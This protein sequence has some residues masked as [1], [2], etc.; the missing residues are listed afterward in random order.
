MAQWLRPSS[1]YVTNIAV[2]AK[3][4]NSV[5]LSTD[6]LQ[7]RIGM[8]KAQLRRPSTATRSA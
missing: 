1:A 2:T 4:P 5:N 6:A 8:K 3:R 7:V